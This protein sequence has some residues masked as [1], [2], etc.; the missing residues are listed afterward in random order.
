MARA[1]G[2]RDIRVRVRTDPERAR[3]RAR[4]LEGSAEGLL[5]GEDIYITAWGRWTH[6]ESSWWFA[7]RE[8]AYRPRNA[9]LVFPAPERAGSIEKTVHEDGSVT[10]RLE[11][12]N[13]AFGLLSFAGPNATVTYRIAYS[14][15]V[16]YVAA[17]SAEPAVADGFAVT[18]DR[19]RGATVERP[20]PLPPATWDEVLAR[21][22]AGTWYS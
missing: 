6:E 9:R 18:M 21:L 7:A 20:D 2:A 13:P 12:A 10:I 14:E 4:V 11:E 8:S 22:E 5:R 15:A 16:P 17:A 19:R 1:D 3:V